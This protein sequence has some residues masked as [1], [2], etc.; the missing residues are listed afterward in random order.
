V[1]GEGGSLFSHGVLAASRSHNDDGSFG[2]QNL[3]LCS[4]LCTCQFIFWMVLQCIIVPFRI[5][6][7]EYKFR[8]SFATG[9]IRHRVLLHTFIV[10]KLNR[11]PHIS[12]LC[13][14]RLY[15]CIHL[16]M[17]VTSLTG[18]VRIGLTTTNSSL[19]HR[20]YHCHFYFN[21]VST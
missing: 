19:D 5:F 2:G 11:G 9:C 7:E 21:I 20:Q 18:T 13:P 17:M 14:I 8:P 4:L 15:R 10:V 6:G 1:G 3:F 12:F 16:N